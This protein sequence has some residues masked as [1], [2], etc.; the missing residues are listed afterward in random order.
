MTG[1]TLHYASTFEQKQCRRTCDIITE[2]TCAFSEKGAAEATRDSAHKRSIANDHYKY[3][4]ESSEHMLKYPQDAT[5]GDQ[6]MGCGTQTGLKTFCA[7]TGLHHHEV[8]AR[9]A[10]I[11]MCYGCSSGLW[12]H[13]SAGAPTVALF[14]TRAPGASVS[15]RPLSKLWAAQAV[16]GPLPFK[17]PK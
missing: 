6:Y 13:C 12:L 2:E 8:V 16:P 14:C 3:L 15:M 9:S 1:R 11:A 7:T 10:D 4:N 17:M 5:C